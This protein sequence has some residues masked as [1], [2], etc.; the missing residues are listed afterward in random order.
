MQQFKKQIDA[1][2]IYWLSELK[3]K[4][5]IA[6]IQKATLTIRYGAE[7]GGESPLKQ[8]KGGHISGKGVFV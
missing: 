4:L 8:G 6:A 2:K 3:R 7:S 1:K 5:L